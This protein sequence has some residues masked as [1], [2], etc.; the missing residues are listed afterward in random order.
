MKQWLDVKQVA[1]HIGVTPITVYRWLSENKI[2]GHRIST[3]A[4]RFDLEEVDRWI[5]RS[6]FKVEKKPTKRKKRAVN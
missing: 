6:Q 3:K 4:W 2:P 1:D 5:K